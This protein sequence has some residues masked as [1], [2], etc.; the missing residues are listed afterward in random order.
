MR[1]LATLCCALVAALTF[2]AAPASAQT[3]T[4]G[5]LVISEFR[6]QGP[7]GANDEYIEIYN[8]SAAAH[9]VVTADGSAGYALA[10]SDGV[11]R[12]TIPAGT[13]IPARGHYLCVNS[14]GYSQANYPA[15]SGT[16]A[17]GDATYTTDIPRNSGIALFNTANALEFNAGT[18]LDAAGS[19]SE[20]N[21]L[22]KEGAGYPNIS[23]F[24]TDYAVFRSLVTGAS[25]DTNDN[26]ADFDVVDTNGTNMCT[27]T[28][29]FRCQQLGAPGPENL[30]S[31]IN[32]TTQIPN[33]VL[34]TCVAPANP[35][36]RVV[37]PC[38][39]SGAGC[40]CA[41]QNATFGTL[42]LRRAFYNNTGAPITRLRFRVTELTTFPVLTGTADLRLV[43]S[44]NAVTPDAPYVVLVD[45]QPCGSGTSL[46]TVQPTTLEEG[47]SG[48]PNGGGINSTVAAGTVTL[49]TVLVP[50]GE[51]NLQFLFGVQQKGTYRFFVM[52]EALP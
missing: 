33:T 11:V 21:A 10:A 25:R 43:T 16:T 39:C 44:A 42:S 18:R 36:N 15:G 23:N 29:N 52:V 41:S 9:T 35:P 40:L 4:A 31:P 26:E 28:V 46:V 7:N 27:S 24:N 32:R 3:A 6:L 47:G 45:R 51:I 48:Q 13:T 12:C 8:N 17:T 20:A 38:P 34:D 37:T 14:V 30:S 19:V 2:C 5:Q 49:G 50:G 22:Y 1:H